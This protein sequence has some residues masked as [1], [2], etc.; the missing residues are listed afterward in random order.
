MCKSNN[1]KSQDEELQ[2]STKSEGLEEHKQP[3]CKMHMEK[4]KLKQTK[5]SWNNNSIQKFM[6]LW[7]MSQIY[8]FMLH[9]HAIHKTLLMV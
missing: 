6:L 4:M 3:I 5:R 7:V 1:I 2:N 8:P 9:N